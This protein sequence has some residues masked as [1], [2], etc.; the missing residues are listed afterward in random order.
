MRSGFSKGII[1]TCD[2]KSSKLLSRDTY[3]SFCKHRKQAIAVERAIAMPIGPVP[4][5]VVN[6]NRFEDFMGLG[7]CGLGQGR[8]IGNFGI[9]PEHSR[10]G[11]RVAA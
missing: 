5:L 4:G 1:A 11:N 10:A 2:F 9:G 3:T 7:S 6:W 8:R